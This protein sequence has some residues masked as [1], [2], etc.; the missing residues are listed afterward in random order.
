MIS[1]EQ[2][3]TITATESGN[4]QWMSPELLFPEH[5]N[6]KEGRPTIAS[7]CYALGMVVYEIL[8][9]RIPFYQHSNY[10]VVLR[11]LQGERPTRPP[12]PE[13]G[14]FTDGIWGMLE[15]CW[16]PQPGDR[17]SAKAML[18]YLEGDQPLAGLPRGLNGDVMMMDVGEQWEE[19]S[20]EDQYVSA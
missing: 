13:G 8:S 12:E 1:E 4:A 6:L 16:K 9:G 14:W 15:L 17:I 20:E 5:F 11:I 19:T 3:V 18:Q 7:D 2:T 10:A